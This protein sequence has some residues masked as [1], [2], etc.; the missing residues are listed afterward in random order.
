MKLLSTLYRDFKLNPTVENYRVATQRLGKLKDKR[1]ID[2]L[3]PA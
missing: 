1:I 3:I 2:L